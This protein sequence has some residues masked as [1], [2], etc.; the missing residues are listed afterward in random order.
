MLDMKSRQANKAFNSMVMGS[1]TSLNLGCSQQ[2][3]HQRFRTLLSRMPLLKDLYVN[4]MLLSK[5][6]VDANG[7]VDL[8]LEGVELNHNKL[9]F[10][11]RDCSVLR[12]PSATNGDLL[13]LAM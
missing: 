13:S 11:T 12:L 6:D 8:T 9:D 3:I 5:L 2:R 1:K 10:L 4:S 7:L